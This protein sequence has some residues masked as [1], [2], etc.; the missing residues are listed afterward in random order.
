LH[1]ASPT[2]LSDGVYFDC[3]Y[4]PTDQTWQRRDLQDAIRYAKLVRKILP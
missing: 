4:V 3:E 2:D 1:F